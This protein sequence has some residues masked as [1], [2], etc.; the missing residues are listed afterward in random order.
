MPPQPA[1]FVRLPAILETLR[2]YEHPHLD[3]RAVEVLLGVG[4]RR[5]RQLMSGLP[6]VRV[7]NAVAVERLA[8]LEHL[9][10]AATGER[11]G[12]ETRRRER[13]S[14]EL[15]RARRSLAGRRVRLSPPGSPAGRRFGALSPD[16]R[17][18]SGELRIGFSSGEDLAAKLLELAQAMAGDWEGFL[19][20]AEA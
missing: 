16:I 12:W 6:G 4:Q 7:G 20:E 13:L 2:A 11:C 10:M 8:L 5:A 3:R 15:E 9:E 17:L 18:G 19:A 14:A 1:W